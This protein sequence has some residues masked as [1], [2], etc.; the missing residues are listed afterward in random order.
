MPIPPDELSAFFDRHY[1][2][3]RKHWDRSVDSGHMTDIALQRREVRMDAIGAILR[4][5]GEGQAVLA[6]NQPPA[7]E[8]APFIVLPRVNC[9]D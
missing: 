7:R 6:Y 9:N 5:L 4:A 1:D 8:P 3:V 2:E